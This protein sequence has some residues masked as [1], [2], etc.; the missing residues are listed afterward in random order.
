M[1]S[2]VCAPEGDENLQ[3]ALAFGAERLW[4]AL[5]GGATAWAVSM[6]GSSLRRHVPNEKAQR[7]G[8]VTTIV[9]AGM[10]LFAIALRNPNFVLDPIFTR[11]PVVID[12]FRQKVRKLV[13]I[14]CC[15]PLGLKMCETD[16]LSP[17]KNP[18]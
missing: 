8:H 14:S 3:T 15:E 10:S 2:L 13:V 9:L 7:L 4:A 16:I 1:F 18:K 6:R 12:W 11:P 5:G 17:K